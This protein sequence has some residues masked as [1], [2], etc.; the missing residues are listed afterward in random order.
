MKHRRFRKQGEER[1]PVGSRWEVKE[2]SWLNK[3]DIV[4]IIKNGEP[5]KHRKVLVQKGVHQGWISVKK[6]K[7]RIFP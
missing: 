1:Y 7:K 4:V 3:R 2:T 6:L 5:G